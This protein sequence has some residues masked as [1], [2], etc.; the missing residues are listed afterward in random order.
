MTNLAANQTFCTNPLVISD[1]TIH[2][3]TEG[4]Y[5]LNDLHKAS[6]REQ[7]HEPNR[8]MRLEQTSELIAEI[9]NAQIWAFE[10]VTSRRGCRGGTY[11]CKELVYAYAMWISASF[12][13]KVIRA[14]DALV[15][16]FAQRKSETSTTTDERT[17]LRAAVSMLVGKKG[18]AYPEAYSFVHQRFAVSHIDELPVETLPEAIEYVHRLALEGELIPKQVP[19]VAPHQIQ[20]RY[21][22]LLTMD[23]IN[24]IGSEVVPEGKEILHPDDAI[25][26]AMRSGDVLLPQNVLREMGPTEVIMACDIAAKRQAHWNNVYAMPHK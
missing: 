21:R 5:S 6:G 16:G 17:P 19:L 11:V 4:R 24:V 10:P 25:E 18:I 3:D 23:G 14:Y 2:C 8:W 22:I 7:R 20:G 1:V 9:I 26:L 12:H 13:L 15:T